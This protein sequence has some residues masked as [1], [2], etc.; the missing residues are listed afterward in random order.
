MEV[1]NPPPGQELQA[2]QR[3]ASTNYFWTM[4]IPLISGWFFSDQD[5]PDSAR[6]AIIDQ[7]FAQRFWPHGDAVG[8]H[9]SA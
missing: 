9:L 7:K 3:N 1:Y 5:N 2:D 4:Q 8:K 6:V